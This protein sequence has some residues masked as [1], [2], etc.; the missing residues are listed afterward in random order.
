MNPNAGSKVNRPHAL[1]LILAGITGA[2]DTLDFRV[3][4][5]FTANQAGN[6]LLVTLTI[7]VMVGTR[8]ANVISS[9][10]PFSDSNM[11][12]LAAYLPRRVGHW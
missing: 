9:T 8:K 7:F 1:A 4:G 12:F 11:V 3:Y 6:L 5:V 2:M 10:G